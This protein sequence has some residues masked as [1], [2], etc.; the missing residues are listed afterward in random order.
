MKLFYF[1]GGGLL[2]GFP[3]DLPSNQ[4]HFFESLGYEIIYVPYPLAPETPFESILSE[5]LNFLKKYNTH[6]SVFYGR[7]AGA[8]LA[9][10]CLEECNPLAM[11]SFY[12]YLMIDDH[13]AK[14]PSKH[15]L[16]Y[17]RVT[18]NT[19]NI[20][21]TPIYEADRYHLY[22]YAR[23]TGR[24]LNLIKYKAHQSLPLNIPIFIWHSL[25]DPDVPYNNAKLIK[26]HYKNSTLVTA[27]Y[28]EHEIDEKHFDDIDSK[29]KSFLKKSS[30]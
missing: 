16:K 20:H 12:G 15:Y 27:L 26:S 30:T 14:T 24:W 19:I 1:H 17:P 5:T 7:S 23:Q 13:W 21:N 18:K 2:S 28:H 10:H 25:F 4:I 6:K 8:F 3:H 22:I 9:L 11:I 29:L